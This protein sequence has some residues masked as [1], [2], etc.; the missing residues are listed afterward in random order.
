MIFAVVYVKVSFLRQSGQGERERKK[1]R[2]ERKERERERICLLVCSP[3]SWGYNSIQIYHLGSWDP[4]TW[5]MF[6]C[7]SCCIGS[8][9]DQNQ[10][11]WDLMR[12]SDLGYQHCRRQFKSQHCPPHKWFESIHPHSRIYYKDHCLTSEQHNQQKPSNNSTVIPPSCSIFLG[13]TIISLITKK[14]NS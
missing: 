9:L 12:C 8:K 3:A 4:K 2:K 7:F 6:S 14:S 10:R 1:E 13:V 5:T 11:S